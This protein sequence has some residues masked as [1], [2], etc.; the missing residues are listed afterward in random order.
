MKAA[1][2]HLGAKGQIVV[3]KAIREQ[4]GLRQGDALMLIVEGERVILRA[5]PA[6]FT[7]ALLGLYKEVWE[8]IDVDKW[9]Q[10]ERASWD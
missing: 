4:L 7:D 6:N 5:R 9:L 10:E 2:V 3:P 8:G 1:M